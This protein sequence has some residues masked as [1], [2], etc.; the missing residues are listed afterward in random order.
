MSS[1]IQKSNKPKAVKNFTD[2]EKNKILEKLTVARVGL[3]LRHPFFGNLATRL[4][5]VDASDWCSTLATDGRKFYYSNDFVNKLT[6]KE[7]EFGFGHEVLHNVFDHIGRRDHRDRKLANIAAD[8]AVNQ[9]LKDEGIGSVPHFIKI[10]QDNKYRGWAFEQI[11]DDLYEKAIKIDISAL[12]EMLDEHLDDDENEGAGGGGDDDENEEGAGGGGGKDDNKKG[13]GR[14]RLSEEEKKAIRDEIK[15]AVISAA[16]ST[17]ASKVPADI[18]KM[19]SNLTEP[20]MDWRQLLRMEIQSIIK[21]N[22]SFSR[23][24]RKSQ[25]CGAILPGLINQQTIDVC[26]AIDMSGSISSQQATDFI[27]E[28]KGIMD[29]YVDFNL[30]IWTF[31]TDVYGYKRFTA[32]N[33]EEIL[34]YNCQGGGGTDFVANW[35]FMKENDIVPKKFIMFTDGYP[36]GEWGDEDYCDTLFV[37]HGNDTI[38]APFGQTAYYT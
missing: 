10:F 25:H 23:P 20:K 3:L 11:Y 4:E 37:I 8:Y 33:S 6:P 32:D 16:Q 13:K 14:P 22:F 36:C 12:G 21:S 9:I 28:V 27:S 24:N 26:C 35:E 29:E 17:D 18:A 34:E 1:V 5:L 30:D 19:I 2:V 15:E 31:D 38:V 7:A